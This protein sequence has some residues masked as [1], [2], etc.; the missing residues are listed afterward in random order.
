[1]VITFVSVSQILKKL[2]LKTHTAYY[3]NIRNSQF[4]QEKKPQKMVKLKTSGQ[5]TSQ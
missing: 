4:Y 5:D 2:C 3:T 1:M